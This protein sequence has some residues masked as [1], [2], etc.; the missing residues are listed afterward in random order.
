MKKLRYYALLMLF[1]ST[2]AANDS[3]LIRES[4]WPGLLS[5]FYEQAKDLLHEVKEHI[6]IIPDSIYHSFIPRHEYHDIV[7]R[8]RHS[9]QDELCEDERSFVQNRMQH[10]KSGLEKMTGIEIDPQRIPKVGLCFSGGGFRSMITTLGFLDGAQQTGLLDTTLYCAGLSGSTWAMA[11]WIAS[12]KSLHEYHQELTGKI[13][14]G[15]DHINDPYELSEL[16]ELFVVKI[17]S[18]Q[19]I[20]AIDIYGGVLANTLLKGFVK[21]PMLTKMTDTHKK[22]DKGKIPLP[23]YTAIM[24]NEEPYEWMEVT[25]FELGSSFLHTYIPTW[26][27]G[28]KFKNGVSTNAPPEQTLGYFMGIFGSAFQLNLKDIVRRTTE[29]L[30]YLGHQLPSWLASALKKLLDLILES[31]VGE[32]RLFPSTLSNFTHNCDFSPIKYDKNISLIDAG[33]DFNLPFPP[34]LRKARGVD[35]IIVYDASADIEGVPELRGVCKYAER[36]GIKLPKIHFDQVDQ[37]VVSVFKDHEDPS[38]P[39]IVYFPR[40]KNIHYSPTFDPD[41]CIESGYCNTFNFEYSP[42]EARLLSGFAEF[43]IKQH[44]EPVKQAILDVMRDKYGYATIPQPTEN[45]LTV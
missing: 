38:V 5:S 32:A 13:S 12:G 35:I 42:E 27:Y 20:S 34:L 2:H 1:C 37:N 29:N 31:F 4:M 9:E 10:I 21:N 45:P 23:I 22:V 7:A 30:T 40:I 36:K 8:I 15:I 25:P 14:S 24:A 41:E 6:K 43:S 26:A 19:L 39:V 11:P 44:Q 17:V 28:R 33:I 3:V 16:L 18:R